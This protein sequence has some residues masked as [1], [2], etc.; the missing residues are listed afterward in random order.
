[1]DGWIGRMYRWLDGWMGG[2][3]DEWISDT[4]YQTL[5]A[6]IF[7][8]G[9]GYSERCYKKCNNYVISCDHSIINCFYDTKNI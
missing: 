2:W 5:S 1:M 7:S 4:L 8:I 3:V 6:I 9:I